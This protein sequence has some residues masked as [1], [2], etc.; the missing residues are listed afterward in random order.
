M[1]NNAKINN[2]VCDKTWSVDIICQNHL[3]YWLFEYF[4]ALSVKHI[5]NGNTQ[6]KGSLKDISSVYGIIVILRD[7][8]IAFNY[9]KI[10]K[11]L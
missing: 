5:C 6:I 7:F 3:E 9:L 8:G 1:N 4:E 2:L 11:I 10:E